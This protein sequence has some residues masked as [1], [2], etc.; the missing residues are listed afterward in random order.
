[1]GA[2]RALGVDV[3]P[4]AGEQVVA[5]GVGLHQPVLDAVVD[6]LREVAGADLAGV[7]EAALGG[8][9]VE[10]GL[11]QRDVLV[12][13]TDHEAVPLGAAPDAAAR[14]GVDVAD[15]VLAVVLGPA[16]AV[17]PTR[18]TAFDGT[19]AGDEQSA[20]PDHGVLAG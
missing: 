19:F 11:G 13:A 9:G 8:E 12:G 5:L 15:A 7:D 6:H 4:G 18:F 10:D 17:A 3:K 2:E 1:P 14:A 20:E 16:D